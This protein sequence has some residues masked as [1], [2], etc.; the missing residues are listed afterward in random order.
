MST[1]QTPASP[2]VPALRVERRFRASP[3][4]VFRAWTTPE[5][6]DRWSDPDPGASTSDVDLRVGGRYTI[7]MARENG[8]THRVTGVYR[9]IDPPHRLVY[10]WRWETIPGFPETVVT[11]TF[12][13]RGDGSTDLVLVHER[14]P[15]GEAGARHQHGWTE[16]LGKLA[17]LVSRGGARPSTRQWRRR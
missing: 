11:V 3:E 12:A 10:T 9:E 16:S 4:R 8:V 7:A 2:V 15:S 14:L 1:I 5:E 6:L 17:A 13:A